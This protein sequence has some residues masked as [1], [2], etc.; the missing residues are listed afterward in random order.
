M[1]L[2]NGQFQIGDIVFGLPEDDIVILE[3][4]LDTGYAATRDQDTEMPRADGI[5]M[6]R[7]YLDSPTY[8]FTL[9]IKNRQTVN[10]LATAW[11]AD[12][13]RTKAGALEELYFRRADEDYVVYGRPRR[14]AVSPAKFEDEE[15]FQI[16]ADFRLIDPFVYS[17][18]QHSLRMG[19]IEMASTGGLVLPETLPWTLAGGSGQRKGVVTVDGYTPTPLTVR[20]YGPRTSTTL[21]NPKITAP[22]FHV[23]LDTDIHSNQI[24]EID[25]RTRTV[26]SDGISLAGYLTPESRLGTKL[27]PGS[28]EFTFSGIDSSYTSEVEFLWRSAAYS[29]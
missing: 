12:H 6:G 16:E 27:L 14:F 28:T 21:S 20:I 5:L 29:I 19:L 7:D 10:E 2:L 9:G 18:E 4:G 22:G 15:W 26:I 17:G 8:A 25:T 1:T 24:V 23:E 13:I 11:R 3:S